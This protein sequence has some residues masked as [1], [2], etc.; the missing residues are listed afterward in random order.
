MAGLDA[1]TAS[2]VLTLAR[3]RARAVRSTADG[4]ASSARWESQRADRF[5]V[6]VYKKNSIALACFVFVFVGVPLGLAVPRAGVGLVAALA[7]GVFL[8]YWVTLVQGEKLADRGLLPPWLGMWAANVVIGIIGAYLVARETRDPSW[9]DPIAT[10][11]G[12][13]QRRKR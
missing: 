3:E 1:G 8:F 10:L 13:V 6:E 12:W 4:A 7:V 2:A 11:A 9:R 5:R